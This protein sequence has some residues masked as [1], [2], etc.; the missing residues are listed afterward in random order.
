MTEELR[1]IRECEDCLQK[2][3]T[4]IQRGCRHSAAPDEKHWGYQICPNPSFITVKYPNFLTLAINSH[5]F[6]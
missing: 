6:I 1:G 4:L 5:I 2:R 3:D